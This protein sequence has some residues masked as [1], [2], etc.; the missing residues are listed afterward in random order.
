M[1]KQ[2]L[3]RANAFIF[4][5]NDGPRRRLP[6][7]GKRGSG[8]ERGSRGPQRQPRPSRPQPRG[9][10]VCFSDADK[11]NRPSAGAKEVLTRLKRR[12]SA[13]G[14]R[15]AVMFCCEKTPAA[16]RFRPK[17][18]KRKAADRPRRSLSL[19]T[20]PN[21]GGGKGAAGPR[22]AYINAKNRPF[23]PFPHRLRAIS[24]PFAG[25]FA[26]QT[27]H[28]NA[29]PSN[30]NPFSSHGNVRTSRPAPPGPHEGAVSGLRALATGRAPKPCPQALFCF[31]DAAAGGSPRPAAPRAPT[32]PGGGA[33][34]R[35]RKKR[36]FFFVRF[37][38]M[39]TFAISTQVR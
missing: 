31:S 3:K 30:G 11:K 35:K 38:R 21:T 15:R 1:Y 2:G 24:S 39:P 9:R 10:L 36:N 25:H 34:A 12:F 17:R 33:F 32:V 20:D 28:G 7:P 5:K 8:H 14:A 6:G 26:A 29:V 27:S 16:P 18:A 13:P 37:K 4:F 19:P 23:P 22:F